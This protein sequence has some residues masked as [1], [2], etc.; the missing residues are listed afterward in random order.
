MEALNSFSA[1]IQALTS[2]AALALSIMVA[3]Q[4]KK[5]K[6]LTDIVVKLYAIVKELKLQTNELSRQSSEL[7]K[8]SITIENRFKLEKLLTL[9]ERMP[10]FEKVDMIVHELENRVTI[11]LKNIGKPAHQIAAMNK[12]ELEFAYRTECPTRQIDHNGTIDINLFFKSREAFMTTIFSFNLYYENGYALAMVQEIS[13]WPGTGTYI[14]SKPE[15][16][17]Q[18]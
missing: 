5:I 12:S 16:H 10:V 15:D 9:H 8:Q 18:Y 2:I 7:E 17:L 13:L 6:E 4:S 1:L 11:R 3:L 14:V